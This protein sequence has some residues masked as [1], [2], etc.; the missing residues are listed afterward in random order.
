MALSGTAKGI[1][2][3]ALGELQIQVSKPNYETW[4]KDTVGLALQGKVFTVGTPRPFAVAWLENRLSSLIRKTLVTI[5]KQDIEVLFVIVPAKGETSVAIAPRMDTHTHLQPHAEPPLYH[6]NPRFTFSSFTVGDCNRLAHASAVGVAES[7]G[8][9]YNPLFIHGKAGLGKTHLLHA[10]GNCAASH[11][12]QIV[13]TST[14]QFTNE[15]IDAVRGKDTGDFRSKFRSPDLLLV[16]DMQFIGGKERT[17]EG[18]YH[19]F[20][21]L[22]NTN[23]QIVITS[24][25]PPQS[26]PLLEASLASRFGG[27]LVVNLQPP[28]FETRLR[29]LQDKAKQQQLSL[30]DEALEFL[31]NHC[32][33]SIRELEGAF[34]RVNA[35]SRL[36]KRQPVTAE[37]AQLALFDTREASSRNS[38]LSSIAA[39]VANYY[40]LS[41]QDL[42]GRKRVAAISQARQLAMYLAR[43]E[44]ASSLAQIGQFFGGRDHSTVLQSCR[45][46]SAELQRD[47]KLRQQIADIQESIRKPI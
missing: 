21:E 34:N 15:F 47:S 46:V 45:R 43:E 4:L 7:P 35:Y 5:V 12:L 27:G 40:Q 39:T 8:S 14:E 33:Q 28:S 1:W 22:Y 6:L 38:D 26:L 11:G 16:D 13:C 18:F 10:I 2:E 36:T 42:I 3:T 9:T 32:Q 41:V 37:I 23:R 17:Q 31:A 24:D 29:I 19:T 25:R 20:N 44:S 30:V